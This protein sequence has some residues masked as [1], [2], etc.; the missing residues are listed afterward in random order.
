MMGQQFVA[1]IIDFVATALSRVLATL[2]ALV[3]HNSP[4]TDFNETLR[5]ES[6]ADMAGLGEAILTQMAC[7]HLDIIS[8]IAGWDNRI[9]RLER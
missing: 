3:I 2:V 7:Y 8:K 9:I 5:A 4:L 1:I 6:K